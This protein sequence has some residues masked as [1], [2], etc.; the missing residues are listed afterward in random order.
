MDDP[1]K[2][3]PLASHPTTRFLPADRTS[4]IDLITWGEPILVLLGVTPFSLNMEVNR[5]V[6]ADGNRDGIGVKIVRDNHP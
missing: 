6:G 1:V 5:V 3:P 4:S 2:N